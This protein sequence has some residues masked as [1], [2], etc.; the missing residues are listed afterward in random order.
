MA[1]S[2]CSRRWRLKRPSSRAATRSLSFWPS[3]VTH[4]ICLRAE[5]GKICS[6]PPRESIS[7]PKGPLN[8]AC[9]DRVLAFPQRSPPWYLAIAACG[10]LRS[11]DDCR[12]RRPSF[13]TGTVGRRRLADDA[14]VSYEPEPTVSRSLRLKNLHSFKRAVWTEADTGVRFFTD[15][16]LRCLHRHA[17][18]AWRAAPWTA[19]GGWG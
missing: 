18:A 4:H 14:S 3:P 16:R 15:R 19:L 9:R 17:L 8:R 7:R 5:I 11:A 10:G 6:K 12:P 13:I 2:R 1:S